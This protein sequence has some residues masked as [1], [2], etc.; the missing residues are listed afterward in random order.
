MADTTITVVRNDEEIEVQVTGYLEKGDPAVFRS[1]S[2]QFESAWVNNEQFELTND[3]IEKAEESLLEVII[4]ETP[5]WVR[6][7][8][9]I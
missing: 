3:E 9:N 2:A 5:A 1:G 7:R 6:K 4:E 8:W